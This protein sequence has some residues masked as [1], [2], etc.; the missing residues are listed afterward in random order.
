LVR[1][2]TTGP[3][4]KENRGRCFGNNE[5]ELDKYAWY[6]ENTSDLD[7]SHAHQVG[8]K[9]PNA[10]GLYD[11][12]GNVAE[13]C[14]DYFKEDYYKQSPAQDPPGPTSGSSRVLRGGSWFNFTR[15]ARSAD[16]DRNDA[17]NRN[18]GSGFRL[19]RELD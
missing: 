4:G 5:K 1:D 10:F 17:D 13:W 14:H 8:I 3:P 6:M 11:M 18:Y 9:K 7:E 19:V 2:P 15:H 12:H 16:R